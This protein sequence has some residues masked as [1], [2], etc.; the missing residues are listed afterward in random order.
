MST[1]ALLLRVS[2]VVVVLVVALIGVFRVV[3]RPVRGETDTYTAI[4]TDANGLRS[5]DDVRLFGVQV[6]KVREVGL[7]GTQAR[8]RFTVT[9]EHPLFTDSKPAI[10]YQNLSGFRYL[11]I[12]Q[13]ANPGA[14]RDPKAV[15]GPSETVPA[16]DITTLFKGLQPVLAE[17]SPDD[18]NR[19]GTSMLAVIQGDG[20][21][22]GPALGAIEQLS[23][24]AS[25]KQA[26]LSTLVGNL[27]QISDHLGGKSGNTVKL[28]T[29]LT[30][31]FIAITD[32]LPGL[33]DF[34][35][36]IPPV[37]QPL[38]SMLTVL[39]VTGDRN[40]DLDTVL[41]NAFP[42]PQEAVDAFGRLP[43]LIQTFTAALP[44]TGPEAQMTCTHGAAVAPP[45]VQVLIAGQRI[46]LC[47]R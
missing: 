15:F 1:R 11:D 39:G 17:L 30:N 46:T 24:Y 41:H 26:V 18:L 13:P 14:R 35:N 43:G 36:A 21:G 7:S 10:R 28:L 31:L 19:F 3:Q 34:A 45:A 6:G 23:R 22:L 29:N 38:R 2:V 8:V 5:G 16:F 9:R 12:E 33:I 44:P 37:L 25:D 32:K 20:T 27:A 47:R 42:D 40:R 4:F